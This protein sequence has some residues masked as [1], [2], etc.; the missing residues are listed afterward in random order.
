MD[1]AAALRKMAEMCSEA[2]ENARENEREFGG[3]ENEERYSKSS[4]D[5]D[6]LTSQEKARFYD[7]IDNNRKGLMVGTNAVLLLDDSPNDAYIPNY[8]LICWYGDKITPSIKAVYK[9]SGSDYN[10]H[11]PEYKLLDSVADLE[12]KGVHYDAI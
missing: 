9:I 3:K 11:N 8:T 1:D 12:N 4:R 5:S 10:I 7:V 6:G 2:Y